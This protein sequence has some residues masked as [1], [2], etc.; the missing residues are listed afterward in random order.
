MRTHLFLVCFLLLSAIQMSAQNSNYVGLDRLIG[1]DFFKKFEELKI[2]IKDKVVQ[3]KLEE[4]KYLDADIENLRNS[5]NTSAEYYNRILEKIK[6]DILDKKERKKMKTYPEAYVKDL[7]IK[8][9][10]AT[11]YYTNSFHKKYLDITGYTGSIPS[12]LIND[13]IQYAQTAIEMISAY[14]KEVKKYDEKLLDKYL[15]QPYK[16]KTWDE[17]T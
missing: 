3:I 11:E 8:L 10:S 13:I 1:S 4:Y 14:K 16:F 9:E 17:I 7:E 6:N 2:S 12:N 15:I 5:Y